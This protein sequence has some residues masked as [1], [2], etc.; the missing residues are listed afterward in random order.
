VQRRLRVGGFV[1]PEEVLEACGRYPGNSG[2]FVRLR[3][4]AEKGTP[5]A[6]LW[7]TGRDASSSSNLAGFNYRLLCRV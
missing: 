3:R 7:Q 4:N 2:R 6:K 5:V 1:F